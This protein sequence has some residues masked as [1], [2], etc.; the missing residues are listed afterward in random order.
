MA[1]QICAGILGR[2]LGPQKG[3][4]G[5]VNQYVGSPV[6]PQRRDMA[7]VLEC[8]DV[9]WVL[10]GSHFANGKTKAEKKNL[11]EEISVSGTQM[12]SILT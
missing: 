10:V 4:S 3:N 12:Q 6:I 5:Y 9:L 2:P 8:P 7:P 11:K 1:E